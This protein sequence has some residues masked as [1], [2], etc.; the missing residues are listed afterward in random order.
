MRRLGRKRGLRAPFPFCA[1]FFFPTGNLSSPCDVMPATDRVAVALIRG[2]KAVAKRSA[3]SLAAGCAGLVAGTLAFG[4]VQFALGNDLTFGA[5]STV[6]PPQYNVN[7]EAKADRLAPP[8]VVPSGTTL[9]FRTPSL[10]DT[11]VVTRI[12]AEDTRAKDPKP[13]TLLRSSV[14]PLPVKRTVACEPA[15]SVLA[16]VAKLLDSSR[17]VT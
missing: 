16:E 14:R 3:I 13:D 5:R 6:M 4:A 9:S 12:P 8:P 1:C 11:L 15:V 2:D 17:C 10:P 7:R